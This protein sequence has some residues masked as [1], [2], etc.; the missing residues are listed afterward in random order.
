MTG[1]T[2]SCVFVVTYF[3]NKVSVDVFRETR[4]FL[5]NLDSQDEPRN[6]L[7]PN[8][9][10]SRHCNLILYFLQRNLHKYFY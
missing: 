7:N 6:L 8:S 2:F 10:F 1:L 4:Q 5:K 3:T 9:L